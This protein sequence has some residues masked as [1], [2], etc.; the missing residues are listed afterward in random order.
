MKFFCVMVWIANIFIWAGEPPDYGG[1]IFGL[2]FVAIGFSGFFISVD[3][4]RRKWREG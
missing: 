4:N 2:M 3:K 1:M